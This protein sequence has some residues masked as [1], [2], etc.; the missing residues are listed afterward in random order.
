VGSIT[1]VVLQSFTS[2]PKKTDELTIITN[3]DADA[4]SKSAVLAESWDG[5]EVNDNYIGENAYEYQTTLKVYD[6]LG[7]THDITI[8][9][10]KGSGSTYEYIVT[11]NPDEDSRTDVGLATDDNGYGML[12]KGI[13][14]F[15]EASGAIEDITFSKFIG[16]G[17]GIDITADNITGTS[18]PTLYHNEDDTLV[19]NEVYTFTVTTAGTN[20]VGDGTAIDIDWEDS[21][22]TLSGS[23]TI[24][25]DYAPGTILDSTDGLPD[26]M[27]LSFSGGSLTLADNFDV[28][29]ANGDSDDLTVNYSWADISTEHVSSDGYFTFNAD[30]LGG[31]NTDMDV[32]INFGSTYSSGTWTNDSLATTQ[33]SSAST[34]TFQSAN[35]YG[36]GDLQSIT[37]GTDGA[38]TGQ[39]SN[40][41]VIPLFRVAL[42]KFQNNQ[43]LFKVGGNLFRET[44]LAQL[45]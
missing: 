43:A 33:Y 1:D 45:P 3:L 32:G 12:G 4:N 38:I 28:T 35:G 30:F 24:P 13:I 9:Y 37:V 8:Y 17:P 21:V 19:A 22:P 11:C 14:T 31:T 23:F 41:Q 2:S 7:S 44:R 20:T 34:T 29:V 15:N 42:A 26:G 18:D 40:G 27:E 25:A 39:Y 16:D 36:A 5:A 6:S 10:D